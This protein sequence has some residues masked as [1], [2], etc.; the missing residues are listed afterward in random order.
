M[1][2]NDILS[3]F[4]RHLN[5]HTQD[6]EPQSQVIPSQVSIHRF[7]EDIKGINAFIGT[8]QSGIVNLKKILKFTQNLQD[9]SDLEHLKIFTQNIIN[10]ATFM[11]VKLFETQLQTSL[12]S[13]TY[14]IFI[15]SPL[16]FLDDKN[17][18]FKTQIA[19]MNAFIE[20]KIIEITELL[21]VL[22]QAVQRAGTS[23]FGDCGYDLKLQNKAF[24]NR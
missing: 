11:G 21:N 23:E 7:S 22:S 19:T 16:P 14:S 5:A 13:N 2:E 24:I 9:E 17:M 15:Q 8:L 1:R 12:E 18:D 4:K 6:L 20:E 10:E 3:T